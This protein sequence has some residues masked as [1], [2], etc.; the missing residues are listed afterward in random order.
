MDSPVCG[1]FFGLIDADEDAMFRLR[2]SFHH[3]A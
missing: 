3:A 2:E 1:R